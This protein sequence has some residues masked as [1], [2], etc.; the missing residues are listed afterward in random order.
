MRSR[1]PA[2]SDLVSCSPAI[3]VDNLPAP[4]LVANSFAAAA[5]KRLY[6]GMRRFGHHLLAGLAD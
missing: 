1:A 5:A 6:H 2:D 4:V 3:A